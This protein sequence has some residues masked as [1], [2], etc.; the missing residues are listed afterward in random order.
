MLLGEF[1]AAFSHGLLVIAAPESTDA[2]NDWDSASALLHAGGDSIY[3]GVADAA[4]S[5][6]HVTCIEDSSVETDL[7]VIWAGRLALPSA[8]LEL[9]DPNETI[10][11]VV[12]VDSNAPAV[13]VYADDDEEPTEVLIRLDP[14]G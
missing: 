8:R 14:L 2:H 11:L 1:R 9:Y 10:R 13:T 7:S 3:C 5:L 12:P 4:T 6:V